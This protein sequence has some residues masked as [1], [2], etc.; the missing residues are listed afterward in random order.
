[1]Y[2]DMQTMRGIGWMWGDGST[3]G[4]GMMGRGMMGGGMMGG[5]PAPSAKPLPDADS[6]GA[7]L[8]SSYCVQCHAAPPPTLH[9]AK[10]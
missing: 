10:E 6:A 7:K 2:Q 3:M 8:V 5:T 1:M 9:T 4:R